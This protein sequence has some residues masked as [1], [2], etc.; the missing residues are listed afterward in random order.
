MASI[1]KDKGNYYRVIFRKT[2][3]T[4]E[5]KVKKSKAFYFK[6]SEYTITQVRDWKSRKEMDF[7]GGDWIPWNDPGQPMKTG[8]TLG[9]AAERYKKRMQKIY[10]ASTCTVREAII[11]HAVS[12]LGAGRSLLGLTSELVN[13]WINEAG[14]LFPTR[15]NRKKVMKVFLS[16]AGKTY[17]VPAMDLEVIATTAE[18]R[19]Y[20]NKQYKSFITEDQLEA[21]VAPLNQDYQDF[22]RLAFYS[23]RR[24]SD[25]LAIRGEWI[26]IEEP[27]L[28]LG[29][30]GGYLPKSQM[31]GVNVLMSNCIKCHTVFRGFLTLHE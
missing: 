11:G 28:T 18:K 21:I 3:N 17:A 1:P 2:Y 27:M 26:S 16:W 25:L 20:H 10:A 31:I 4:R 23:T 15:G 6:K 8:P 13:D 14:I 5:G 7:K 19:R 30:H 24:R 12:Y 9:E 22:Y 29:E